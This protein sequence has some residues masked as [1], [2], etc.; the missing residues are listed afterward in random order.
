MHQEKSL[1]KIVHSYLGER[2]DTQTAI[3][4]EG[5]LPF[6]LWNVIKS[7]CPSN[8]GQCNLV[9]APEDLEFIY[10]GKAAWQCILS[11]LPSTGAYYEYYKLKMKKRHRNYSI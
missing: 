10:A 9:Q 8:N 7:G 6:K 5:K 4:N 2:V 1:S 11:R 3:H